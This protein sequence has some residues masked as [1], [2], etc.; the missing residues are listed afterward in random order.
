MPTKNNIKILYVVSAGTMTGGATKSFITMLEEAL[1]AGIEC[2]VVCPENE[3]LAEYL[4]SIGVKVHV[5]PYRL[6]ALP[7]LKSPI[8][9]LKWI[10]RFA[11]Y[12][13][14]NFKAVKCLVGDVKNFSPDIVHEN[15]SATNI[16]YKLA[17]K[18][19]AAYVMH[20]REYGWP[21]FKLAIPDFKKR[22]ADKNTFEIAITKDLIR[23]RGL[24]DNQNAV[25]IY[26][27]IIKEESIRYNA[28]KD[29][30]FL[31]LGKINPGK[32]V[33][34]L[35][36]AYIIY[37]KKEKYPF[38]LNIAGESTTPGYKEMLKEK[39]ANEDLSDKVNW[40][41]VRN[42]VDDLTYNTSAVIVT[43]YKEGLGRVF[44]EAMANGCLCVGRYSGGTKE[45]IDNGRSFTGDDIAL[46]FDSVDE[47]ANILSEITKEKR[48]GNAFGENGKYSKIIMS[49]QSS[50][51]NFFTDKGFGKRLIDFYD[52]ILST[53]F[54]ERGPVERSQQ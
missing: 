27:G 44:P 36:D 21:D 11:M 25:Q 33:S 47:L 4:K 15:T 29:D 52:R 51:K 41:G 9:V 42:D 17:K 31:Y 2:E 28:E 34:D 8:D 18:T 22:V 48:N 20:I 1:N 24:S 13:W 19:G 37:A 16:G 39:V 49:S 10:P 14:I 7:Q 6:W 53:V 45:Q 38:I 12:W 23:Y 30:S 32:G 54:P 46:A 5:V 40:L 3:G 26:N 43:S 50:V 35:I